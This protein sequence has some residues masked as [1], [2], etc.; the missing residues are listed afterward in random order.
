[1]ERSE[2]KFF[3]LASHG[4]DVRE[5]SLP[6]TLLQRFRTPNRFNLAQKRNG[7]LAVPVRRVDHIRPWSC[8]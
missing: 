3:T 6:R 1:M 5:G 2:R 7:N 8:G 4:G